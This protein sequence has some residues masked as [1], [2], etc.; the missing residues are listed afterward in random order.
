VRVWWWRLEIFLYTYVH[1]A[2]ARSG[3]ASGGHVVMGWVVPIFA[4]YIEDMVVVVAGIGRTFFF[5]D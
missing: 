2:F 3:G 4:R 5:F 1:F